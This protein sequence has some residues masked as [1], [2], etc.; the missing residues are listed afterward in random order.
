MGLAFRGSI[1]LVSNL[2]FKKSKVG[3]LKS[4]FGKPTLDFALFLASFIGSW[5]GIP[6]LMKY[7]RNRDDNLNYL[8]GGAVAGISILFSRSNDI[9]MY[10]L[11]KA[12]E[13]IYD[14]LAK[15]NIVKKFTYGDVALFSL[16][17]GVVFYC[18]VLEPYNLRPSY[19][20]F[21]HR[22]S[23]GRYNQFEEIARVWRPEFFE[24]TG[25]TYSK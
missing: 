13:T 14:E 20:I 2:L 4:S 21:L 12:M 10:F 25:F 9:T 6:H 16:A 11:A 15:R 3:I 24:K 17:V 8:V 19:W 18:S 5:R 23:K 1:N 7:L 22:M